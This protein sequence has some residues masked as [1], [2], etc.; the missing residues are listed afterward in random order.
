MTGDQKPRISMRGA[1][2]RDNGHIRAIFFD[3]GGV[4]ARLDRELLVA[5]ETRHSLPEGSFIKALYT[6]PEW[7]AAE[8]GEE[9]EE[10]WLEAARRRLDELAGR[11]LPDFL[12]ERSWMWRR[13]DPDVLR[14]IERLGAR[15]DV[16]LLS[17]ATDRLDD[18]L[19]GYHKI[20]GLFKVIV[21]SSRVGMAKPDARIYHLAAER[22]GAEPSACVHIDDLPHNVEGAREAGFRGIHHNGDYPAL[23]G[24]LRALGVQW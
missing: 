7:K 17:N 19:R 16:G 11:P 24:A 3:F 1:E 6:I 20:D 13:L 12:E 5:F 4:V 23:E 10:G 22:I 9:T 14:L 18:E 2:D 8:L 15:Y 21:N